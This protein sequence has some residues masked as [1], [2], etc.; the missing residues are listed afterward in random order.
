M[1]ADTRA[2]GRQCEP[3][4]PEHSSPMYRAVGPLDG[5]KEF[6]KGNGKFTVN[7]ALMVDGISLLCV[8]S[9]PGLGLM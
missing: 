7:P 6:I 8:V 1:T 3:V 9:A 2:I 4:R 5:T